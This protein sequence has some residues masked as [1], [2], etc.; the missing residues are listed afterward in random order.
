MAITLAA[1]G[2]PI[3]GSTIAGEGVDVRVDL[4][5]QDYV[6]DL[7]GLRYDV[8]IERG[9]TLIDYRI[10]IGDFARQG[11]IF[12]EGEETGDVVF[13]GSEARRV[14]GFELRDQRAETLANFLEIEGL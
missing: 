12:N 3:Q 7:V 5:G 9:E 6:A 13:G 14:V 2:W 10:E 8:G 1:T 11:S 4:A